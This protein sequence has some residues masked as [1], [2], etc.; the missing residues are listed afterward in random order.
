MNGLL[1]CDSPETFCTHDVLP[2]LFYLARENDK[3]YR[4]ISCK[5]LSSRDHKNDLVIGFKVVCS[6]FLTHEFFTHEF[7]HDLAQSL[8]LNDGRSNTPSL[9]GLYPTNS[10]QTFFILFP[11]PKPIARR[12]QTVD[13]RNTAVP[14]ATDASD[15]KKNRPCTSEAVCRPFSFCSG[16]TD[17]PTHSY[18]RE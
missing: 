6:H 5:Y 17:L 7:S 13:L 3:V 14:T 1:L 2:Q 8:H 12:A 11:T 18:G 16:H 4:F 9:L 10:P 15:I